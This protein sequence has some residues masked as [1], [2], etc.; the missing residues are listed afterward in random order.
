[1]TDRTHA[2]CP[3]CGQRYLIDEAKGTVVNIQVDYSGN[4][5][6]RQAVNRARNALIIF[7]SVAAIL[8]IIILGFNIAAKKSVFSSS[9]S[10]LA[11]G[12]ELLQIFFQDLF[13]KDYKDITVQELESIRYIKCSYERDKGENFNSISY[14]FTDYEDCESEEEFQDTIETWTYRTNRVTWP[15]DYT[16]LTGLTRIDTTDSV[17]M[18]L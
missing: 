11:V 9:D 10:D 2:V 5:E 8:V 18:S 12:G 7:L 3:Y 13:G 17:W 15:S 1:M 14:S 4:N 16:M 6:M